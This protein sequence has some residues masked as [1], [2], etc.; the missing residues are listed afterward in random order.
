MNHR[1]PAPTSRLTFHQMTTNSLDDMT[2]L[3][4]DPDVMRYYSGPKTREQAQAWIDWNQRLYQEK[5]FGLW[6]ITHRETDE[7]IGDCGLTPQEIEG[8]IDIEVGYHVRTDR[9][10]QGYATE[11]ATACRDHARDVLGTK[12]LI[13]IVHPDNTPSQR[14]AEKAGLSFE[15][16]ATSRTGEPVRIYAASF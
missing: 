16:D 4:C 15:R 12:R 11:A 8:T 7:F 5:G 9:Q 1:I 14:V 2:A 13:A 10:G 3:L 6:V